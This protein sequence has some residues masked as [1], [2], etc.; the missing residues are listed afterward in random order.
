MKASIDNCGNCRYYDPTDDNLTGK[1]RRDG[2]GVCRIMSYPEEFDNI[3]AYVT[4]RDAVVIVLGEPREDEPF[5]CTLYKV[6]K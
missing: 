1:Q 4:N 3:F 6:G 5:H 2:M